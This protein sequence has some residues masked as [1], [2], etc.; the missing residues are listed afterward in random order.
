MPATL[1]LNSK[2]DRQTAK[3]WLD[4]APAGSRVTFE[5]PRR[6]LDQNA[7]LWAILTDISRAQPRGLQHTPDIWKCLMMKACGHEVQFLMGLDGHPFPAGFRSSKMDKEQM[8]QLI[9]FALSWGAEEGVHFSDEAR[10]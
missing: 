10:Q 1:I 8:S 7:K 9:E 5:R 4:K 6:S 3:D 2:R